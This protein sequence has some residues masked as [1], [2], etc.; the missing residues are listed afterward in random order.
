MEQPDH[1]YRQ[2]MDP[3][4]TNNRGGPLG[5]TAKAAPHGDGAPEV[6]LPHSH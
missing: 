4:F 1:P 6:R 5:N 3:N 2:R